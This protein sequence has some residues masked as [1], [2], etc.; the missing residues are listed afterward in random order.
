MALDQ[1]KEKGYAEKYYG[2][3]REKI[4]IGINF[5]SESKTVDDWKYEVL[6][7]KVV[8]PKKMPISY[9]MG[10]FTNKCTQKKWKITH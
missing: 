8:T 9:F 2:D 10:I 4:L 1:I 5:D 6:E 3:D 7:W